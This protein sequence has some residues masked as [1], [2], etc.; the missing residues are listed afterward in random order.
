MSTTALTVTIK[1]PVEDVFAVLTHIENAAKWSR[2]IEE[3]LT[4]PGPMGIGTRRHAVVPT[5]GGRTTENEMELTD[6]EPNR[7]LAMRGIS[8]FPF[9]VRIVIEFNRLGDATRLDWLV[10]FEPGGLLRPMAPLFG[11]VYKRSFAKDLENLK[12]MMEAGAL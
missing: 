11:A 2:A 8:G 10:S 5:F 9:E 12:A 3:T 4:T 1:R 7:R 6:F